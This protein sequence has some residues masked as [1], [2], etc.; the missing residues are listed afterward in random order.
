M[1]DQSLREF[2]AEQEAAR[3]EENQRILNENRTLRRA[4][5][6]RDVALSEATRRLSMLEAVESAVLS[7]PKWLTPPKRKG[8]A[9]KATPAMVVGDIHWGEV[10][11]PEEIGGLN[12]YNRK[13]AGMRLRNAFSGAVKLCR[14]YVSGL[15]YEGFVCMLPG[16]MVSGDIHEELKETNEVTTPESVFEVAE[17]LVAGIRVLADHFGTVYVPCTVGNHGRLTKKPRSKGQAVE[18]FDWM[19]YRLIAHELRDDKRVTVQIATGPDIHF[20][21]YSTKFC[22]THGDQFKGGSG[23]AGELSPLLLGMHR[24]KVRDAGTGSPWDVLVMAHWHRRTP[25][26]ELIVSGAVVG[27]NEFANRC[28]F[29]YQDPSCELWLN[30]PERGIMG[31]L[32]VYPMDRKAEGW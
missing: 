25:L 15:E 24:K 30:T 14:D 23:I 22:L 4:L 16:D 3:F 31:H 8:E 29:R 19:V 9:H 26:H 1:S 20:P 5:G 32:P 21:I 17:H 2:A 13:I 28:N 6:D 27:Y 11:K 10:V 7:P 12:C 18:S